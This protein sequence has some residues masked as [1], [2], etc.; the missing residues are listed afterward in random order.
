MSNNPYAN[1]GMPQQNFPPQFPGGNFA[2]PPPPKSSSSTTLIIVLVVGGVIPGE[3][4][5]TTV[6]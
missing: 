1:Q 2:P 6:R 3:G 5:T 4:S